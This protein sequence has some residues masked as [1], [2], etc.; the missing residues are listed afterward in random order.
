MAVPTVK[1]HEVAAAL[2]DAG[3]DLLVEKPLAA[4][5]A[6]ADDLIARAEKRRENSAAGA[7]G[8]VQSGG[9]GGGTES[10]AADVF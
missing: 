4:N 2:L 3:L 1:H 9:A 7:S 8:A 6:D 5:L 10:E